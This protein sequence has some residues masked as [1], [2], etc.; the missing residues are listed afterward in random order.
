MATNF[1][2]KHMLSNPTDIFCP[3]INVGLQYHLYIK[4]QK[5]EMMSFV[6]DDT[7]EAPGFPLSNFLRKNK[8]GI[9]RQARNLASQSVDRR[10]HDEEVYH[11]NK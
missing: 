7:N 8:V 4:I 11:S 2:K 5:M 10:A 1:P 3:R 9:G 6:S